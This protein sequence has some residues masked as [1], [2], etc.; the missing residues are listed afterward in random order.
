MQRSV[1]AEDLRI[2]DVLALPFGRSATVETVMV[3]R[4]Y[5]TVRTEHGA[6]RLDRHEEIMLEGEVE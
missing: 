1:L 5:V 2:G 4:T 3:G 6:S